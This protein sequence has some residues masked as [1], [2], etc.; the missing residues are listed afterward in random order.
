[1][2]ECM[3]QK[4]T[5]TDDGRGTAL[6]PTIGALRYALL[7]ALDMQQRDAHVVRGRQ[8]VDAQHERGDQDY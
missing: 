3:E 5:T 8:G 7:Y 6:R 2:V 4:R 1:M